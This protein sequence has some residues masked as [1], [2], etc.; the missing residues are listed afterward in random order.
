MNKIV[1]LLRTGGKQ[2]DCKLLPYILSSRNKTS[3]QTVSCEKK[4]C[5]EKTSKKCEKK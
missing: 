3:K 2:W 1:E 4:S 5:K